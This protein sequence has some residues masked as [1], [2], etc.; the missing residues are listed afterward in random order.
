[1]TSGSYTTNFNDSGTHTVTV[2]V[3]DGTLTDSQAVTVIVL[4]SNSAPVLDPIS[5][6]TV[7]EGAT[8]TLSPTATDPDGDALTYTYSGWMSSASYTTDNNDAGSHT[9]TVT[10]SDGSL[11]DSQDV[12]VTV[13]NT[14]LPPNGIVDNGDPGA[15]YIGSWTVSS[16]PNPYG[17]NSLYSDEPG[18]TYTFL[19]SEV[20]DTYEVSLWWTDHN[21]R[22]NSVPV[23]IYDGNSLID[24]VYVDHLANGGQWNVLGTYG[25]ISGTVRVV[26]NSQGSCT[27]SAD[28]VKFVVADTILPSTPANLQATAISTSQINLSWNT[29]SD[30]IGVTGYRIYRDGIQVADVSGTTYQDTGLSSS[31]TYSYTVSA[32]DAAGNES[33]QSTPVST[34]ANISPEIPTG[35]KIVGT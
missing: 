11:I 32:Y 3:S 12:T 1:M 6:I 21:S 33:S 31:T 13:S 27:T 2:T 30:N 19:A 17:S 28:A 20:N 35:L 29:S 4:N 10:V 7:N 14:S 34:A 22:C 9:V 18:A 26:I 15:S 23:D 24:T 25:F 5:D 8:I 16:G